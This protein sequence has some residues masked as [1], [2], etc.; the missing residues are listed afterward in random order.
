[1]IR[2]YLAEDRIACIQIFKSNSPQY[3]DNSELTDFELWLN[4]QD[5]KIL[6]YRNSKVEQ[7]FVIEEENKVVGCGGYYIITDTLIANMAW[8][9]IDHSW[10]KQGLGHQLFKFRIDEIKKAHP[11][12]S[13]SLNT[14]QHTFP[15]F[16]RFGF[17]VTKITK[18]GFANGMDKYEMLLMSKDLV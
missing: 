17:K 7:Y 9:M 4:G 13:I 2:P 16:E 8:G 11:N 14:S 3:F 18:D 15:F 10:H 1:M 6:A 5:Q 12:H